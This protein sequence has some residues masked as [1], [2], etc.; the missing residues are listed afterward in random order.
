VTGRHGSDVVQA[1]DE[2]LVLAD[3]DRAG[4]LRRLFE[5]S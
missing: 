1:G 2:V 4:A 3:P 5:G